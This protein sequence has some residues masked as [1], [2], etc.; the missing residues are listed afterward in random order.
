MTQKEKNISL[1]EL[2]EKA[3]ELGIKSVSKYKKSEL[4]ELSIEAL[5]QID[6]KRYD[7]EM[8]EDGIDNLIKLGIAFS[9]KKV[10]IKA[11]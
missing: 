5:M 6:E 2:R 9:G 4:E 1:N 8:R 3:K 7:L 11:K 10:V